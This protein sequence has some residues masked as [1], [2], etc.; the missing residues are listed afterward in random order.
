[1]KYRSAALCA[2]FICLMPIGAAAQ[3]I[4]D[5]VVKAVA[6]PNRPQA[7]TS[8]DFRRATAESMA[9]ATVKPG[10]KVLDIDPGSGFASR[11]FSK[12]VGDQGHIYALV[13]PDNL[14]AR[15]EAYETLK[16]TAANPA[17]GGNITVKVQSLNDFSLP[18]PVDVA[19]IVHDYHPKKFA[20]ATTDTLK[21]NKAVFAA[22]RKGGVYYISDHSGAKGTGASQAEKLNRIEPALVRA[23]AEAAGFVFDGESAALANPKDN[24]TLHTRDKAIVGF[25]D[26]FMYRFRKP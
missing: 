6:D 26:Q 15:P 1:M 10:D 17:Y 9:F 16:K 8:R 19:W 25:T 7:D 21:M 22:L 3:Q 20:G 14:K 2:A 13:S 11:I 24:H 12:I 23:E 18:E 4:P 5:Y